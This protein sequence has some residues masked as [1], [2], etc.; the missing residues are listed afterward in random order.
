[1]EL[2]NNTQADSFLF[3]NIWYGVTFSVNGYIVSSKIDEFYRVKTKLDFIKVRKIRGIK[4][5]KQKI[6]LY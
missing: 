1:M 2:F 6:G 4:K 3:E 5:W